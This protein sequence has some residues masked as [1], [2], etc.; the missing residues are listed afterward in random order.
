MKKYTNEQIFEMYVLQDRS[1]GFIHDETGLPKKDIKK[2][3]EEAE[4]KY[5]V[6]LKGLT[7]SCEKHEKF[8]FDRFL[9]WLDD[10]MW[11]TVDSL[12]SFRD[13]VANEHSRSYLSGEIFALEELSKRIIQRLDEVA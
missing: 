13:H 5:R 7:M 8:L 11:Q 9:K 1:I 3:I 2:M 10:D 4:R 12:K 6:Q